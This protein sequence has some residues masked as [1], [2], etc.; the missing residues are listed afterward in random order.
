M[1]LD[2][3]AHF[4]SYVNNL[5]PYE[6]GGMYGVLEEILSTTF[7]PLW[8]KLLTGMRRKQ[9]RNKSEDEEYSDDDEDLCVE[10]KI[11]V[12]VRLANTHLT[13]GENSRHPGQNL[14]HLIKK[15]KAFLIEF[16]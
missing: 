9:M 1:G 2:G 11:Q 5:N 8:S 12:I 6:H 16:V 13:P 14:E 3:T 15:F 7:V 4:T 10:L